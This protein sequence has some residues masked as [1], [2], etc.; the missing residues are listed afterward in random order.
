MLYYS[1]K[2]NN[3]LCGILPLLRQGD[4]MK[5]LKP[6]LF[7]LAAAG[8]GHASAGGLSKEYRQCMNATYGDTDVIQKCLKKELKIQ[9]EDLEKYYKKYLKNA[10]PYE[11]NYKTQHRLWESR[12]NKVCYFNSNSVHVAIRQAKCVLGMT[13]ERAGYYEKKTSA[14]E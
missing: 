12:M 2:H 6:I 5:L 1:V 10:G 3:S 9:N 4:C 11:E 13:A 8:A 14:F 7:C